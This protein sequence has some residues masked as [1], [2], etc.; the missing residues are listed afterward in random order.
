MLAYNIHISQ[1]NVATRLR[2]G[3]DFNDSFIANCPQSMPVKELLKSVNIW[4][5]YGQKVSWHVFD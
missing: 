5:R 1:G 2:C 4:L 3:G